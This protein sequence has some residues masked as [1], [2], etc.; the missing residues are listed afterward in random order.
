MDIRDRD[1]QARETSTENGE[2]MSSRWVVTSEYW[3]MGGEGEGGVGRERNNDNKKAEK[4]W[5][6]IEKK[7]ETRKY[8][9]HERH[10]ANETSDDIEGLQSAK[11]NG[12]A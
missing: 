4:V 8:R 12:A 3:S 11:G 7:G 6:R 1:D 10:E 9:R 2:M 5:E